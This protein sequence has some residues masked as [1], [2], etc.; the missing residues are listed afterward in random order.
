MYGDVE[1]NPGPDND[2]HTPQTPDLPEDL[3]KS[4]K[5]RTCSSIA[6]FK[7]ALQN[8]HILQ[9]FTKKDEKEASE[10]QQVVEWMKLFY[11][12]RDFSDH[13]QWQRLL[14]TQLLIRTMNPT[15]WAYDK[16]H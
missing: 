12:E 6:T 16:W 8:K 2:T 7:Y 1:K 15:F 4:L 9:L 5:N 14:L 11:P 10:W 13:K 3:L